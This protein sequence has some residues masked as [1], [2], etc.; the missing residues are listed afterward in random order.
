MAYQRSEDG[1][2]WWRGGRVSVSRNERCRGV[3]AS[4]SRCSGPIALAWRPGAFSHAHQTVV[5]AFATATCR[6]A[7]GDTLAQ[8][9]R[10]QRQAEQ[11]KQQNGKRPTHFLN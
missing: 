11:Q 3:G 7:V 9:R 1:C 6:H 8:Q 2:R 10:E 4:R 5:L